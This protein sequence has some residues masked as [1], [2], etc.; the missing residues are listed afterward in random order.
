MY[1]TDMATDEAFS[2]ELAFDLAVVGVA[3]LDVSEHREG[4]LMSVISFYVNEIIHN[5][6]ME[7]EPMKAQYIIVS[8]LSD[9][10]TNYPHVEEFVK[11]VS[12]VWNE[13]EK[14]RQ[15]VILQTNNL[16]AN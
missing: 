1:L 14:V 11:T 7:N 10:C 6:H 12:R 9:L 15:P 3:S 5:C 4:L 16:P 2:A 8:S 13:I